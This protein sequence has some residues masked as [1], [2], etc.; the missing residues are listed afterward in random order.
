L[1]RGG[2]VYASGTVGRLLSRRSLGPGNYTLQVRTGAHSVTRFKV[3][4]G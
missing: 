2:K 4:L 1:L 3:R